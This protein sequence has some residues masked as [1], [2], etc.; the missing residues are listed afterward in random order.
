MK[1]TL[2]AFI[3]GCLISVSHAIV[4]P[5]LSDLKVSKLYD[6]EDKNQPNRSIE[7]FEG[8][9]NELI[10]Y[11][12]PSPSQGDAGTCLFMAHTGV[13]E[14]WL[15]KLY[16]PSEPVMLSS[17]YFI[18][19]STGGIGTSH[20]QEWKTDTGLRLNEE[21]VFY[22]N[23]SFRFTK[24]WYTMGEDRIRTPALPNEPKASYGPSYNWITGARHSRL[25]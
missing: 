20:V 13:L 22:E 8:G 14:W 1:K 23:D 3:I 15:N 25:P 11:V 18:N 12:Q 9:Y 19:L 5:E 21:Q 10:S 16:Q 7:T 2:L 17:R 24:G 4:L 6:F